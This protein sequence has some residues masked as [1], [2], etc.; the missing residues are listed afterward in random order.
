[1]SKTA[2]IT[3]ATSGIGA[4][5]AK[6][7]A[8]QGY[9]L[10]ITGRRKEIIQKL[11]DDLT[12]QYNIKVKVII[13]ELSNDSDIQKVVDATKAAENLEILVNNAGYAVPLVP[14]VQNDP[15]ENERNLKVLVGVPMRLISAAIP[16]MT[17]RGHGTIINISSAAAFLPV[18]KRAVYAASKAFVKSFS[19]SLSLEVKNKGIQV[20][21]VCPGMTDTDFFRGLSKEEKAI[22]MKNFKVMSPE[23]VVDCSLK[24][25][26]RKR[27]VCI[28]GMYDRVLIA[29]TRTFPWF[30]KLLFK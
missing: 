14:F 19:E 12:K 18:R 4:A 6:R 1:M 26:Q 17:K 20:L 2:L 30:S 27:V 10:I 21:A 24:D 25:L 9:D 23:S 28:P 15:L 7:L 13:A 16:E 8:G 5:Y 22:H 29:T 3:G 11:A